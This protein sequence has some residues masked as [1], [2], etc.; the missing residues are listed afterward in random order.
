[1]IAATIAGCAPPGGDV[2]AAVDGV[3]IQADALARRARTHPAY[4]LV[5]EA[6]DDGG[7]TALPDAPTWRAT[8]ERD[9][10]ED[11]IHEE[12]I[13]RAADEAAVTLDDDVAAAEWLRRAAVRRT[14][15]VAYTPWMQPYVDGAE[16]E[17]RAAW[18]AASLEEAVAAHYATSY[19]GEPLGPDDADWVADAYAAA[20]IVIEPMHGCF[21]ASNG[22]VFERDP[23]GAMCR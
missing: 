7:L 10:L 3:V 21:D 19:A 17:L 18:Q 15:T 8:I 23:L 1:M 5:Y 4:H 13:R 14:F 2:V 6:A 9:V 11:M 12:I 20:D 22:H 16:A